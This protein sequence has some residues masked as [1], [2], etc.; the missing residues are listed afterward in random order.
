M[1]KIA[2]VGNPNAGKTSLYNRITASSERVG[3]WH[4]VTVQKR[5]KVITHGDGKVSVAVTDLPGLYS[6]TIYSPDEAVSRDAVIQKQNDLLINVCEVHNLAR[7]LYLTLQLLEIGAN[8]VL[9]VNMTDELVKLGKV[10]NYGQLEKNLRIPV[11]PTS[12]KVKADASV[13][14][15]AAMERLF[16]IEESTEPLV[17]LK[18]S[19]LDGL[20]LSEVKAIIAPNTEAAGLNARYAAIKVLEN[21]SFVLEKLSL[22]DLQTEKIKALGDWQARVA[23]ARYSFID[24]LLRG[25]IV[26]D[27][28]YEDHKKSEESQALAPQSLGDE[29]IN[30]LNLQPRVRSKTAAF[31]VALDKIFLNR[32]FALPAFFAIMVLGFFISF[33]LIGTPLSNFL[34]FLITRFIQEP[35]VAALYGLGTP[36]WLQSLVGDGIISG[37]AAILVFVPKIIML[38]LFLAFLEDTGYI[39]RVAFMTDGLFR[40]VGL[41]G[42]AVFTMLTGFGCSATAILTARGIEDEMTRKKTVILT[43]FMSCSAKLPIFALLAGT[44]FRF[45]PLVIFGLYILGVVVAILLA[46]LMQKIKAFKSGRLS[47]IMEI[48][49]YRAPSPLRIFTLIWQRLKVFLVRV[50]TVIFALTVIVWLLSS[51]SPAVGFIAG[52]ED[53]ASSRS[54]L[55]LLAGFI[56]P[57][58]RP[59]GFGNWEAVTALLSGLVAKELVVT[60]LA[61]LSGAEGV[62]AVFSSNLA[63]LSF[64]VFVLLYSPCFAALGAMK[65]EVG[66]KWTALGFGIMT[67]AAYLFALL[68]YGIGLLFSNHAGMTVTVLIAV[69]VGAIVLLSLVNMGKS[70]GGCTGCGG[71][72]GE[73]NNEV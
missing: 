35:V 36:A 47:F 62:T 9:A 4:G 73:N 7:N 16:S 39:S 33:G 43:P 44:F 30:G 29:G 68:T 26:T 57:V 14:I 2:L 46:A 19:Y 69:A 41:S 17:R 67:A 65:K 48:P 34:G 38:F 52:S 40:R 51:F 66:F 42:R 53:A 32:Y 64:L 10:L 22:T 72:S 50:G 55:E 3:N 56:A 60:S 63:A 18:L 58:F 24:R 5:E 70:K 23:A 21:D 20:P 25:V 61:A 45:G 59:L 27:A 71:C 37:M 12:A 6:L 31:V 11:V 49:P 54:L 1:R 28:E 13:L 8:I 15:N